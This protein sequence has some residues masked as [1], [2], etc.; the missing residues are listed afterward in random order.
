MRHEERAEHDCSEIGRRIGVGE[1]QQPERDTDL[2]NQHP[3]ASP[4][5]N[6][7]QHRYRHA[8]D[9]GRPEH[10]DRVQDPDPSQHPDGRALDTSLPQ[11][12]RQGLEHEHEREPGRE[13]QE[14]HRGDAR[15]A[16]NQQCVQPASHARSA[17]GRG[18]RS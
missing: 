15:L 16:V 13:A 14:Q 11:P 2:R 12:G 9:D 1:I 5:K 18:Q 4:A 8:I 10:F 17:R 7:I 3:A 6:P